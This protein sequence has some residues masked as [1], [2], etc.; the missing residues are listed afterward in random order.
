MVRFG[1]VRF[2]GSVRLGFGSFRG[3]VRSSS[4]RLA[5]RFGKKWFG[6]VRFRNPSPTPYRGY[7]FVIIYLFSHKEFFLMYFHVYK[8]FPKGN[9]D[10]D[11]DNLDYIIYIDP[12]SVIILKVSPWEMPYKREN[13]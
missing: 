5:V 6:S 9:F 3:S 10:D 7:T 12:L 4:V 11:A 8:A 1:S 13:T 2:A